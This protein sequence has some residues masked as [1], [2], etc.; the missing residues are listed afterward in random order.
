MDVVN[1]NELQGY[2]AK[3]GH[4]IKTTAQLLGISANTFSRKLHGKAEFTLAEASILVNELG[5]GDPGPVFFAPD[6]PNPQRAELPSEGVTN[7]G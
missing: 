3:N 7:Y 1:T 5:I 2:M 4:N 6:V